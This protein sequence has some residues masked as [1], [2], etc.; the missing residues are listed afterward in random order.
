[1]GRTGAAKTPVISAKALGAMPQ[2][3]LGELGEKG[4]YK[5]LSSA[6][7]PIH[8][9]ENRDGYIPE[10]AM[11]NFVSEVARALG[12]DGLALLWAPLITVRDYGV[13]DD[14]IL[15]AATLDA[16]LRR[17]Q[18]VMPFH[19]NTDSVH[20]NVHGALAEYQYYFG[21]RDHS[22]YP[23]IAYTALASMLSIFRQYLGATWAPVRINMDIPKP[24]VANIVRETFGCPIQYMSKN[25]SIIFYSKDLAARNLVSREPR[26]TTLQDIIRERADGPPRCLSSLVRSVL[27]QRIATPE[28][29]LETTAITLDIGPRKL[30]RELEKEGMTFRSIMNKVRAERAIEL[31]SLPGQSVG[32]VSS[33]LGYTSPT[34]FRRA[35]KKETGLAPANYL[36]RYTHKVAK[37]DAPVVS[38][39]RL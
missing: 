8:F 29:N 14:F 31:L 20:L 32:R 11:A 5:A 19:S 26:Q 15:S 17:G 16:A 27:H 10:V 12:Q 13:W 7:L 18:G 33:D 9:L 23:D 36:Q 30:Q 2:F 24:T 6:G 38:A 3:A 37:C 1:L 39:I 22:A 35:L 34:N 25:L 21:L 28:F 4:A